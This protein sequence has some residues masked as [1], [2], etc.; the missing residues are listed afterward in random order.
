M[1]ETAE[2]AG[3]LQAAPAAVPNLGKRESSVSKFT[4]AAL[5]YDLGG[6]FLV[7]G[8]AAVIGKQP[9]TG[10]GFL[11]AAA[12]VIPGIRWVT[13]RVRDVAQQRAEREKPAVE[14]AAQKP[15]LQKR[16]QALID[17]EACRN[18]RVVTGEVN[19]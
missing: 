6:F 11:G 7:T 10:L 2:Q 4:R 17:A 12:L 9:T 1:T 8:L 14:L 15:A 16:L 18:N 19:G 3:A 5:L 13:Y